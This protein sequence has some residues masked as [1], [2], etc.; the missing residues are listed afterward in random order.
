MSDLK[1][2]HTNKTVRVFPGG[3]AISRSFGDAR[4]KLYDLNG[5]PNTIICEPEINEFK[6]TNEHDFIVIGSDGIF[7]KLENEKI[8]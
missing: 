4:S 7:D 8:S 1:N 6:I 3:L 5:N 2:N